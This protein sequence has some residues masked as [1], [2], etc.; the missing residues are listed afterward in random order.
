M[1]P[2]REGQRRSEERFFDEGGFFTGDHRARFV[3]PQQP[4]LSAPTSTEFPFRLNTGRVRDQWHT[5]TRTGLS[6]RLGAHSPEPF[7]EIHPDDAKVAKLADGGFAKV[8][9]RYGTAIFK[10]LL[11]TGQRPGSIFAP[12]HWSDATA[13]YARVG[14]VVTGANDPFSGQPEWPPRLHRRRLEPIEYAFRGFAL[15]RRPISLPAGT[16][17]ARLA[18]TGGS[19]V[20]FATNERPQVWHDFARGL[21][22]KEAELAEYT[23]ERLSLIRVAFLHSGR[24]EGC[25][26]IGPAGSLP[27]WDVVRSLFQSG[28]LLGAPTAHFAFRTWRLGKG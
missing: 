10:V 2:A 27:Q 3:A 9:T 21:M 23:D 7:V 11:Q 16:W 12:I 17:F 22:P 18:V 15:T 5:M 26:F 8:T 1:W 28:I 20:C 13:G 4:R 24:L 14:D 25:I 6:P 19:G